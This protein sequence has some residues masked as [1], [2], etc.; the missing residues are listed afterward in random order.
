MKSTAA[1]TVAWLGAGFGFGLGWVRIRGRVRDRVWVWVWA[2]AWAWAWVG[3]EVRARARA[4]LPVGA[5]VVEEGSLTVR[6]LGLGECGRVEVVID[7]AG[8][9]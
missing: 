2:W 8:V 5:R 3:V 6:K 4:N 1:V 9:R 7:G